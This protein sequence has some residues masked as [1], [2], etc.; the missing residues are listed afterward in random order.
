MEPDAAAS[1]GFDST[2]SAQR[3]IL[4]HETAR[5]LGPDVA[6]APEI[7]SNEFRK[8]IAIG[9]GR[10][11]LLVRSSLVRVRRERPEE[12]C[13][14]MIRFAANLV[15]TV[16]LAAIALLVAAAV[17]SGVRV[18][19]RGFLIAVV[20]FAAAQAILSPFVFNM[21]R[22][23]ASAM[24]GGIGLVSTL[25]ALFVAS[26]FSGGLTI[27]GVTAWILTPLIVWVVTALGG[28]ILLGLVLRRWLD[29]RRSVPRA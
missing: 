16:V 15:A 20:V 22:K 6:R 29:R 2:R 23:Y 25:L 4:L 24:L 19:A 11:Y 27:D 12:S 10:I 9:E 7:V 8:A 14:E 18:Q 21:A 26:R 3:N 28:W 13:Q 5:N 17:V 1:P